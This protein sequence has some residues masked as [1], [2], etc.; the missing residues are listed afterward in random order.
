MKAFTFTYL[1]NYRNHGQNAEQSIRFHLIGEILKADNLRFDKG[2]DVLNFQV[3][4]AKATICKGTDLEKYLDL[5]ASTAYIYATRN[6]TAYIM[7][8]AEYIA[9]VKAFGYVT[10]ES[11][12]NGGAE[13]IRLRDE[14]KKMLAWLREKL[15]QLFPKIQTAIFICKGLR[16]ILNPFL[17][18]HACIPMNNYALGDSLSHT[19]ALKF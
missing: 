4:S 2:A 7:E 6:G 12:K 3:K 5:D 17:H 15:K 11:E 8:K 16:L 18:I 13:K 10:R 9:F 14:S 1:N 19:K